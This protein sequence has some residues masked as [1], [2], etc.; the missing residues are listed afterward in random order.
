MID[1]IIHSSAAITLI[2]GGEA[3]TVDLKEA[4]RIAPICV[5]ADGGVV[6]ALE[7]GIMPEAVLGDFDSAPSAVLGQIPPARLHRIDE[8]DTTDFEKALARIDA[9]VI[10]GAGFLGGRVDHQLAALHGLLA[11]ADRPCVLL[12][13]DEVIL[14]APPK[15]ALPTR[16]GDVVSLFPLADAAG[17]SAGL[18]WP[19]DG[20]NFALGEK[21]GTS[22]AA[23]GPMSLQMEQPGLALILPRRLMPDV[24]AALCQPDAARWPARGR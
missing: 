9:P 1:P 4:L 16:A 15:I 12:G 2:G 19:I 5:A 24:V 8:Q 13:R 7:A 20:L 6:L 14:L 21:I 3:N 17:Q 10:L 23:T 22:N 18:E 11:F